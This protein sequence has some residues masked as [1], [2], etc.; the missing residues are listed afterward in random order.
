MASRRIL[1]ASAACLA[2]CGAAAMAAEGPGLENRDFPPAQVGTILSHV[3][4]GAAISGVAMHRGYLIVPM[5]ADHGGGQGAGC[6]TVFDVSNLSA[7]VEVF[8]SRDE[9]ARYQTSSSPDYFGDFAEMHHL[10]ISGDRILV[11]ERH[12]ASG[13]FSI[14]D[15]SPLYDESPATKP[16]IV[17]RYIFPGGSP[18]SNYDGFSFAPAWQ[19]S[20]YVYAPTGSGGL[21][22]VDTSDP[23][24]PVLIRHMPRSALANMTLRSATAIGNLLILNS[25]AVET[26][27]TALVM[28]I[29]DP[30]D[31]KQISSFGGPLGY[32]GFVYGG[33]FYG[34][35]KPIVRHDFSNP[36]N[37]V[38]TTLA[39]GSV[40]NQLDRQE[41][42]FGKDENIFIG[43]YP[44]STK[45][46]ITG[47]TATFVNRIDSGIVPADDHAFLTPLGNAVAITTDH[48]NPRK[49]IFGL[50]DAVKDSRPPVPNFH[51]PSANATNVSLTS[52]IGVCFTDYIDAGSLDTTSFR[53]R[54]IGQQASIP[55]SVGVKEGIVNFVPAANLLPNTTYEVFLQGNGI[56][57]YSGNAVPSDTIVF[58]FSTGQA[59]SEYSTIVET[60]APAVM[61]STVNMHLAVNNIGGQSLEH[62]WDF[63]DGSPATT[64]STAVD[65]SHTYS[66]PGNHLVTV[67]TRM[68][69][70]TYATAV[71]NVQVI[72]RPIPA[73]APARSSTIAMDAVN[74]KV[75]TVNPDNGSIS[76]ILTSDNTRAHEIPVGSDPKSL[77][78]G[79]DNRLWIA[80]KESSTLSVVNRATGAVVATHPLPPGSAPHGI[81]VHPS[82]PRAYVCLEGRREV[83]EIDTASGVVLRTVATLE[84][85]RSLALDPIGGTLW[86]G[87]FISPE[88]AGKVTAVDL[89]GFTAATVVDLAP[90]M[91]EDTASGGMGLPNYL[92]S[93]A[94]S[95]DYSH[96]YVPAKKDNVFR[97]TRRNG[98]DLT[99]EHTVRSMAS[100]IDLQARTETASRRLD[101]D[102]SDFVTA[103]AYS[104]Q[105]NQVFFAS[106]GSSFIWVIDAYG[107]GAP[108]SI[109]TGGLAPDGL[110]VSPD[111][112]RLYVHNF[113]S[114]TV[115]VLATSTVC[116]GFC[117][118]SPLKAVVPTVTTDALAADVLRGKQ[119]FYNTEDPRLASDSYMSCASCHLDGGHDGR[120]WDF[121]G[122]G[123]GF[124]NTID[125][126]GRGLGHGPLHWTANFDEAHDFEGQIRDL[127]G[128]TGLMKNSDFHG[129]TLSRPLG[130]S[131]AGYSSDLDALAAYV[132]SL[133]T[134]GRSPYREAGGSLSADAVLG[135]EIFRQENCASCHSG[136]TFTDSASLTRHDVGTL[137]VN[138][139]ERLG[140]EL[141]GL[142]TP[143]LRG[144]WK[145]APYLHDGSAATLREVLVDRD[146]SGRHANLF[147]RSSAE[148]DQLVAY[149]LQIDD[150]ETSAPGSTVN[151][152]PVI[153]S[154]PK[155]VSSV[156]QPVNLQVV[157]SDPDGGALTYH[158]MGLPDG[159]W[160][161]E[162]TGA[163]SGAPSMVAGFTAHVSVRDAAGA[164]A[165]MSFAWDVLTYSS[166]PVMA[167]AV[168]GEFRYVKFVSL[169]THDNSL[170]TVVSEFNVLDGNLQAMNRAGWSVT[171][172]SEETAQENGRATRA[173]D[174]Q[175]NTFWHTRWSGG[176]PPPH[177]HHLIID[178]LTTRSV[179]GFSIAPR[180]DAAGGRVRDWEFYGS[181]DGTTWTPVSTGSLANT[182]STQAVETLIQDEQ[183]VEKFRY[184]K[185]EALTPHEDYLWAVVSEFNVLDARGLS[186]NRTGWAIT[187]D[188]EETAQENGRATRAFDGQGGT[189]WHTRWSG[190]NLPGYPHHLT[191]DMLS[192][193]HVGGFSIA[194]R[195]D[196]ATGRVRTW[197]FHGSHDGSTW[198]LLGEGS[199]SSI[200]ETQ[201]RYVSGTRGHATWETWSNVTGALTADARYPEFPNSMQLRSSFEAPA[202][203]G[204]N[205]GSRMRAYLTPPVT[206][207]Y[208]L[209][210]SGDDEAV[211]RMSPTYEESRAMEIA[212]VPSATN[213]REWGRFPVQQ[214]APV[215]LVAG[216]LY[217]IEALHR[218]GTG[219]DHLA[220]AWTGPGT[221]TPTV[222]AGQ[223]LMPVGPVPGPQMLSAP[224]VSPVFVVAEGLPAGTAVGSIQAS[225]GPFVYQI[226]G[227][228]AAGKFAINSA[229]GAITLAGELDYETTPQ[230]LLTALATGASGEAISFHI[231]VTVANR[232][233]TNEEAVRL[234]LTGPGGAFEGHGNPALIGFA[235]DPDG[236]GIANA[237]EVLFG[238]DAGAS[239][240][241]RPIRFVPVEVG[242]ETRMAYEFQVAASATE[243]LEFRC[244]GSSDL[245]SW[246]RLAAEPQI[247]A[248]ANDLRTYRVVDD[249]PLSDGGRRMMR[250][251]LEP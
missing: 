7:P 11:A 13:G 191:I 143:T 130:Q 121:S 146:I 166:V 213:P 43:H 128:G 92:G 110:A 36:Q 86:V 245:Q 124:R 248:E 153:T 39:S 107:G 145:T 60:A 223:H 168:A 198:K 54:V 77:A 132:Q 174:G 152:P 193:R 53:V 138:S 29:S 2:L 169:S 211:L 6:L 65:A 16:G 215:N 214:S 25:A 194:P 156:Q 66:T 125:L 14:L 94:I 251:S 163:I 192:P 97:G 78:L 18:P 217:Y 113:M 129:G 189:F 35:G 141:D 249:V 126:N 122:M 228:N 190:D 155:Q 63:G 219:N 84:W 167:P 209:W 19:G 9:P 45:W 23:E 135:R 74:G 170:W 104:P 232:I 136:S 109:G 106:S 142:D 48:N 226:T 233:E 239:D 225:G 173:F 212:S 4:T 108:Y 89:A 26:S 112:S 162:S 58:R 202:N 208:R 57:D 15:M 76:G 240:A 210:I 206:G 234:A 119:I 171:A 8:D 250:I 44:G 227:G 55:G 116:A 28:D 68:A 24:E 246:T 181:N 37:V 148:I 179:G 46:R 133:T 72:H 69:G 176:N 197:R 182:A 33:S 12:G 59:V 70:Q 42:G 102:N 10:S 231:T 243:V 96:L 82:Q 221:T 115:T 32:Q 195:Q 196:S 185:F 93:L 73:Q 90:V 99:F 118:S 241:L 47:N 154:L 127:S 41:Y 50:H 175:T 40:L 144:L 158:A 137:G 27:F 164:S 34:A 101:F 1:T 71:S 20:R 100:S 216:R 222:I 31:P 244:M 49:L 75:W 17:S 123:E 5:G 200:F 131:K 201:N 61:G 51:S 187:T 62:S 103:L 203:A 52:R 79:P 147:H 230:H 242:G 150:L 178:M 237:F 235:S 3:D 220:V 149:L 188:S 117:G 87:H 177:P 88:D 95:P 204:N 165:T 111:G 207:S 205:F 184:V 105:G 85:P 160:I 161:D 21:Y 159:L 140:G 56:R 83:V 81:V 180:Q 247:I 30:A 157:A 183:E 134:V 218:D 64:Y 120:V 238:N 172:D 98:L 229:T 186:M 38:A 224:D 22:V 151:Q 199:L 139:G 114:R 67:R 80:N 91:D 236:D